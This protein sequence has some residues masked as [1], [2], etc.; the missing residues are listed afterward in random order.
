MT[1]AAISIAVVGLYL[2]CSKEE[3]V[4]SDVRSAD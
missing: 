4:D 1:N 2:Y 3:V